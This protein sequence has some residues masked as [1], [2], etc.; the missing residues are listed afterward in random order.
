MSENDKPAADERP[1]SAKRRPKNERK[2]WAESY[3]GGDLH[4]ELGHMNTEE[5]YLQSGEAEALREM[6]NELY[7]DGESDG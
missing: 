6:L 4:I 5:L 3:P 7:E 1:R 2:V